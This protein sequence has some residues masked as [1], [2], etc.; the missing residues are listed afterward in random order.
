MMTA[1]NIEQYQNACRACLATTG[2]MNDFFDTQLNGISVDQVYSMCTQTLAYRDDRLPTLMCRAC[3]NILETVYTFLEVCRAS[4]QKLRNALCKSEPVSHVEVEVK[5]EKFEEEIFAEEIRT[6]YG[7]ITESLTESSRAVEATVEY[8]YDSSD[9]HQRR[10]KH[11][12][13]KQTNKS[14]A[15]GN[16]FAFIE[17]KAEEQPHS[18]NPLPGSTS[19]RMF[20]CLDCGEELATPET[21]IDHIKEEYLRKVN[22]AEFLCEHCSM[23]TKSL[24]KLSA[25]VKCHPEQKSSRCDI[26]SE[27]FET[28]SH[29][30]H[31]IQKKHR[32]MGARPFA[33][34]ECPKSKMANHSI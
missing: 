12:T 21:Y 34:P 30:T 28:Q 17:N 3:L 9:C 16:G 15:N 8:Y 20:K 19:I 11:F 6:H 33:C 7:N 26:C 2:E 1:S 32:R 4:D 13:R 18:A 27:T 5:V 14:Q 10:V 31:H 22:E 24:D 23:T 25:H 29:L